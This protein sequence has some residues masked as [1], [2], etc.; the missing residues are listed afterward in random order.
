[1]L[2]PL[3]SASPAK[4]SQYLYL[5]LATVAPLL[6]S[7]SLSY[8]ATAWIYSHRRSL[9]A[10]VF[11]LPMFW[12]LK[13]FSRGFS[14]PPTATQPALLALSSTH[15]LPVVFPFRTSRCFC[16]STWVWTGITKLKK[17][18]QA[19]ASVSAPTHDLSRTPDGLERRQARDQILEMH[20]KL[21]FLRLD[22]QLKLANGPSWLYKRTAEQMNSE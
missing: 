9:W 14:K 10:I 17:V 18:R 21:L 6:P 15:K 13:W 8:N 7:F 3:L 20:E 22:T 12:H 5:A 16:S 1:M 4:A 11:S 19:R 2:S